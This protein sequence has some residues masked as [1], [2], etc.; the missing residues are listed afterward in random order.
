VANLGIKMAQLGH[1]SL[2]G[3]LE[4]LIVHP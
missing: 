4:E 3:H 1:E 2:P